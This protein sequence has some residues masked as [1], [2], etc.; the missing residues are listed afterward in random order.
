MVWEYA[1]LI[2]NEAVA[3]IYV[4][5]GHSLPHFPVVKIKFVMENRCS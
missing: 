1:D 4:N 2:I 5:P 3:K